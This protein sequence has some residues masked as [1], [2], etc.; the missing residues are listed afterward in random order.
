MS[1]RVGSDALVIILIK[2]LGLGIAVSP[3][4]AC[5]SDCVVVVAEPSSAETG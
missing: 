3:G 4:L 1:D 5:A 2:D